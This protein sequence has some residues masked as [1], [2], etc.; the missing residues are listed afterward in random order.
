LIEALNDEQLRIRAA[1]MAVLCRVAHFDTV[2]VMP[3]VR[4]NLS[5]LMRQ[6]QNSQ[7]QVLRHES[8]QLLQAMVRGSGILLK[9][10]VAQILDLLMK[11]LDDPSPAIGEAALSTTGELSMASPELLR[12]HMDHIIPLIVDALNDQTSVKKQEIAVVVLGKL[13]T[14]L[15]ITSGLYTN[16]PSLFESLVTVIK[17]KDDELST[18]R[19][20]AIRTAGL[21]GV[22]EPAVFQNYIASSKTGLS[23]MAATGKTMR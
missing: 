15:N 1:A 5:A 16:Y 13:V 19:L 17:A 9:P 22:V 6:L 23:A 11:L 12:R 4:Q 3:L 7:D 18:L 20:Q 8:M 14:S 10:Y 21:L 2:H